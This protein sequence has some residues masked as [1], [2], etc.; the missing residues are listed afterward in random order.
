[1]A[2]RLIA[3]LVLALSLLPVALLLPGGESDP[4]YWARLVDWVN[5]LGLGG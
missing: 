5:G 4:E 3:L 2:T 1:M